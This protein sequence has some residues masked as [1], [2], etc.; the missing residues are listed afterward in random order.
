MLL[1]IK[2]TCI[3]QPSK[4]LAHKMIDSFKVI[5]KKDFY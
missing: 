4:K 5:R 2:N 1:S 3:N